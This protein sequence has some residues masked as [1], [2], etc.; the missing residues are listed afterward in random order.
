MDASG[1]DQNSGFTRLGQE[2]SES[3]CLKSCKEISGAV[4][5]EYHVAGGCQVH[6]KEVVKGNGNEDYTCFV[7]PETGLTFANETKSL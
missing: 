3:E 1:N 7:F 2:P 6:T 5:C 4:G